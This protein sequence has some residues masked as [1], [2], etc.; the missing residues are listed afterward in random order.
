MYNKPTNE[1]HIRND[2]DAES[3]AHV[4]SVFEIKADISLGNE[5]LIHLEWKTCM[6]LEKMPN[7][8]TAT[9]PPLHFKKNSSTSPPSA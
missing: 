6:K 3:L 2:N 7:L 1:D 8:L 9:E 5:T 4:Q